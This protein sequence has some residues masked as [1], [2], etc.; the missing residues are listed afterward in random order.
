MTTTDDTSVPA[1]SKDPKQETEATT[2]QHNARSA[3]AR[4]SSEE[5]WWS[6]LYE[7]QDADLDTHSGT[8]QAGRYDQVS[9][10]KSEVEAASGA[11]QAFEGEEGIPEVDAD[12]DGAS[13]PL[14]GSGP[15]P[16]AA[17][18]TGPDDAEAE[19]E[20]EVVQ[21]PRPRSWAWTG[22]AARQSLG[23][24]RELKSLAV[25]RRI[26]LSYTPAAI[27]FFYFHLDKHVDPFLAGA[28]VDPAATTGA[29]LAVAA[30]VLVFRLSTLAQR[31]I[32]R[33]LNLPNGVPYGGLATLVLCL[34]AANVAYGAGGLTVTG[35]LYAQGIDPSQWVVWI[36][37]ALC[38]IASYWFI[39]RRT[40]HWPWPFACAAR[41]PTTTIALSLGTFVISF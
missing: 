9:P 22:A 20:P 32:S 5:D 28:V 6:D 29:L 15:V 37:G 3:A 30:L 13:G 17:A 34:L 18:K 10:G 26:G 1:L 2:Q 38:A 31:A 23:A 24:A 16:I 14:A 21:A 19:Y 12:F 39:D 25:R 7:D 36:A 41:I 8:P 27:A 11:A 35:Y 4:A 33:L 40:S